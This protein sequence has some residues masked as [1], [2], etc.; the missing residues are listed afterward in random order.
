MIYIY[1]F[2]IS[3]TPPLTLP[4]LLA[5]QITSNPSLSPLKNIQVRKQLIFILKKI[6]FIQL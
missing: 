5:L 2:N 1:I 6:N 3:G 4:N